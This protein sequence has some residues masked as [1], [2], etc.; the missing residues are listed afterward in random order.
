MNI[1]DIA[2]LANVSSATVSRVLNN[3]SSV[4]SKTKEK[5]LSVIKEAQYTPNAFAQGL[6][7]N[8]MKMIGIL[9]TDVA[10]LYY[11]NA[12]SVIEVGLQK[13][14]INSILCCT[15]YE[16]ESKK[17]AIATLL[18]KRVDA[19]IL[20]GSIFKEEDENLHVQEAA[21]IIPII[22]INAYFDF[23]NVYS[24]YCDEKNAVNKLVY[25]M[26]KSGCKEPAII[27]RMPT[28]SAKNKLIGYN[29]AMQELCKKSATLQLSE[30]SEVELEN[31]M[32]EISAFL[33][34]NPQ[35][36]ALIGVDD[37]IAVT[38]LKAMQKDGR[39]LPLV[40]INNSILCECSTPT[41]SSIDNRVR[42]LSDVAVKTLIELIEGKTAP[43]TQIFSSEL[44][45]RESYL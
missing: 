13:A 44:V 17:N 31:D 35:I 32:L 38:A 1:H 12:V 37:L 34:Q 29:E 36:D 5:V 40:G 42:E 27:Y 15:G 14:H 30:L 6:G 23:E 41:L 45:K 22:A 8:S 21:K 43:K 9:C 16:I 7:H 33:Q 11:G 3:S 19:I 10:Q 39:V 25:D 28:F 18:S 20:V 24:I 2:R 26:D 4:A